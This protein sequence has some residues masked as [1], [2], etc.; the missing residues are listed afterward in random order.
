MK[1]LLILYLLLVPDKEIL[2]YRQLLH[3]S[4]SNATVA[5]TFYE[6]LKNSRTEKPLVGGYKGMSAFMMSKHL[7]NPLTK[8]TYFK[9]GK[10]NLEA[11]IKAD[12]A[13]IELLYLRFSVQCNLPAFL[14]Y[15]SNIDQDK[16]KILAFLKNKNSGDEDLYERIYSFMLTAKQV[17]VSEKKAITTNKL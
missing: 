17:S 14:N 16:K 9:T 12:P 11:A 1:T 15:N 4:E 5:K 7:S 6:R 3:Q 13:S 10:N 2:L 8:L